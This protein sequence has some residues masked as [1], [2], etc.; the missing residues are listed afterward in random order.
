M[1]A[2]HSLLGMVRRRRWVMA[3]LSVL[4]VLCT[5]LI[6]ARIWIASNG[7]RAFLEAQIDGREA[8]P[9]GTVEIDGLRGDPLDQM[10]VARLTISDEDG[11][12]LT[13]EGIDLAWSPARLVSRTVKLDLIGADR[14]NVIRRPILSQRDERNSSG[15]SNWAVSLDTLAIDELLLQEGVAGPTAAFEIDGNFS[16]P[17]TRTFE[18]ALTALPLEGAGDRIDARLTRNA[19]GAFRIDA[20]IEAPAGGTIATL[21]NLPEGE[22]ATLIARASGTLESGDGFAE[23]KLSDAT[24]AELTA[25]ITDGKLRANTTI[26]AERLPVS[27]RV[28]Q[29]VGQS[30]RVTLDAETGKKKAPFELSAN[31]A[32]GTLSA[33]GTYRSGKRDLDGPL[34]LDLSFTGFET[35]TDFSADLTFTGQLADPLGIPTLSGDATLNR[36]DG[37]DLPFDQISGPVKIR[38]NEQT[39]KF[40]GQLAGK[41][42]LKSN[43]T[44]LRILGKTPSMQ[45]AGEYDRTSGELS[46]SP[47]TAQLERGRAD[48]SGNVSTRDKTLDL[49]VKLQN[50]SGLLS[51]APNLSA[52]GVLALNGT[53]DAPNISADLR[54]QNID[55]LNAIAVD[56]LGASARL[57][58]DIQRKGKTFVVRSA[59]LDG[60]NLSATGSGK[61]AASDATDL[62]VQLAQSDALSISGTQ[63]QLGTGTVRLTGSNGIDAVHFASS[64]GRLARDSVEIEG[65]ETTIELQNEDNSWAGPVELAGQMGQQPVAVNATASWADSVFALRNISSRYDTAQLSGSLVYGGDIGLDMNLNATGDRFAFESRRVGLFDI[66]VQIRRPPEE[67][68]SIIAS[69]DV[70][71][72]WLSPSLRFDSVTGKIQNAP[73]GYNFAVQIERDHDARPTSLDMLG[74][75]DFAADYP[76]GQIELD[77]TL[78]GEA[79]RSVQ[80]VSWRLGDTPSIEANLAM[81]GG[82]IEARI[83]ED[84]RTPRM[85]FE[86]ANV[87]LAPVMASA[88]IATRRVMVNG[89]G[90]FLLFG[91]NPEG[92]FDMEVEGPLPGLERSLA[93]ELVGQLR[94]QALTIEGAGDYGDLRLAGAASLPVSANPDGIAH[95]NMDAPVEGTANL[96]GDLSDLRSLALA[97]GHDI[98]GIIDAS[99][100]LSGPLKS[101]QFSAHADLSDGIYE[102]G[103]TSLRLVNLSLEAAYG[104]NELRLNGSGDGA[105]GGSAKILG[106]LSNDNTSLETEFSDLLLY[107]R[108]GDSLRADGDISLTGDAVSRTVNGK[109]DIESAEFNLDNLPSSKAQA[110]DVRWMEDGEFA[111]GESEFRQSLALDLAITADRRVYIDGRGLESEWSANLKLT[112]TAAD[113]QL[114]GRASMRRGTLALAGRPFVFDSGT[115]Y[116]DGP[117]QRARLDIEAERSVNGFEATVALTGSP[118]RPDIELSSTPDLPEDEILSRLL[119]GRSSVDL[120]ALEAAQL[121]NSIAQL[122]GNSTGFDP[123]SE[124]QAALGVDRLSFGTSEE[125]TAQVGVGQ[126]IAEDVYLELNSAG[127][128][129]SS[130]EVEWEPRPQVSVTSETTTDGEARLSIKWKKDY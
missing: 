99:A 12:W 32:S 41:G 71:D 122:S 121:A 93:I 127:A 20:D 125:G 67:D 65:L 52:G 19:S 31:V 118:M 42:I 105:D 104:D 5:I 94:G 62:V 57:R 130:V 58:G 30:A 59:S 64:G 39:I 79:V 106:A 22:N 28:R 23:L 119:F 101:P 68:A 76:S 111:A 126:Y 129:G 85:K 2:F 40:E 10:S 98:G 115:V 15:S 6:A 60:S 50:V 33:N 92:Q 74:S 35:L 108:D 124:L 37:S 55:A 24:V 7:G 63:I 45:V 91:A 113:P 38:S 96:N 18:L 34:N 51:T 120:S 16:L 117:I 3:A 75:A 128:A 54:I 110:I 36:R 21:T 48:A 114:N 49:Q 109:L 107:N 90:D 14:I 44:A 43:K 27:D 1:A 89:R 100:S 84:T 123:T 80:P 4:L 11:V 70:R 112:G 73:E 17:K 97:Y 72:V 87:D 47:S 78:L 88:G 9:L 82:S 8:G 77:G 116:F 66:A 53:F 56:A 29:L 83:E 26:N 86:I 95:L 61:F 81:F 25:K 103:A 69:G 13:A 46:L 102:F